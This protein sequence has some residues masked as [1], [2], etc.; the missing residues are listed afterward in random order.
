EKAYL[1]SR[2]MA[3]GPGYV[4]KRGDPDAGAVLIKLNWLNGT[5]QLFAPAPPGYGGGFGDRK[6]IARTGDE[7]IEDERVERQ[8]ESALR[9]DPDIWVLEIEDK[10][11]R[12]FFE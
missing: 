3:G 12:T 8:V 6:F 11:G 7:P 4:V 10:Q 5:A 1:R 9:V 2:A